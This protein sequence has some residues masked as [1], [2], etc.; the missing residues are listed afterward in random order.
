MGNVPQIGR[1]EQEILTAI[2]ETYISTGEP[3]GSRTLSRNNR[4]GLSA[5][6]IRNVMADLAEAGL[7]QQ[8]HTS[9]GRVPSVE[10]YRYYVERL[11]GNTQLKPEE[12]QSLQTFFQGT[13]DVQDFME[14]TSHV[15][16]LVSHGVG[17]A[18]ATA[19]PKNALEHV[20]FQRLTEQ[21]VLAV[22]VTR[23]GV[24]RDRV[25]R[26]QQELQ[27]NDL[28]LAARY[29]N[30]NFRGWTMEDLQREL[31]RRLEQERSEYDRL[32]R[33]LEQL[34]QSGALASDV[35]SQDVYVEGIANLVNRQEDAER[36]RQL[37]A[38]LEE[39]QRVVELLTAYLDAQHEAVRVV[40]GLQQAMPDMGNFVLIGAP[41]RVGQEVLGKLAVIGP[42][43][44]D[45]QS[46]IHAVSYI[47]RLFDKILNDPE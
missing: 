22:V 10:G 16:S 44:M 34:Y 30:D 21:R 24:V 18:I 13:T 31:S 32:M 11:S 39:K 46:T 40:I 3:V 25:F 36:L 14:R 42:T 35:A 45:Y 4:E 2:V 1:R 43:R 47:T 23:N 37:L 38:T 26:I 6:T 20:H 5:A 17:V 12:E 27:Q 7:L 9:A 41:A 33:S 19:G 8:P 28:D 29:I 15:L